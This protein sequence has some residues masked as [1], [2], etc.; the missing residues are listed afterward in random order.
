MKMK[1]TDV[2]VIGGS[3]AGIVAATTGKTFYPDKDFLLLRKE[4]EVMVPC[5]IP[6]IFGTLEN[7]GQNVI[8]DAALTWKTCSSFPKT[9]YILINSGKS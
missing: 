2:L 5:G 8:L 4:K 1:K 3:A 6:Y 7:S 9:R